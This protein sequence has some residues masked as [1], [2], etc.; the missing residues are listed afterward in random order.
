MTQRVKATINICSS[1]KKS[2]KSVLG[3][4]PSCIFGPKGVS[5]FEN[6]T[7]SKESGFLENQVLKWSSAPENVLIIKRLGSETDTGFKSIASWLINEQKL[8]VYVEEKLLLEESIKSS[9]DFACTFK[10]LKPY[11]CHPNFGTSGQQIVDLIITVG[12]DGTLLYAAALFEY[13]MP[14]VIAFNAG[15]L[16][17]LTTHDLKKYKE[18]VTSVLKGKATLMLRSR[19][20]CKLIRYIL[21]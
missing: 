11:N 2:S 15:S 4:T 8:H 1:K 6:S 3:P 14:P 10:K 7:D 19:L 20:R 13:S 16:G 9:P 5:S 21:H 12:G 18:T 17:F